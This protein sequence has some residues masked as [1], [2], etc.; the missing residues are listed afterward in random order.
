MRRSAAR[1]RMAAQTSEPEDR[2][3]HHGPTAPY[4]LLTE[5]Q[6]EEVFA[7][8]L[9]LLAETGVVFEPGTEADAMFR[10]AGCSISQDGIV[11]IPA[12]ITRRALDAT[13]R[14]AKLWNRDG[15]KA[16]EIDCN[17]TWFFPGMTCIKIFDIETG[18][19]RAS[20]RNDLA[21]ITRLA[22]GLANIDGVCVACKNVSRTDEFGEI[23]EFTC[24][25]E[26]T[27]KP[28]EYLC[29]NA[30]SLAAVIEMAATI[31]GGHEKLR[32]KPYF[33]Q[34]VTPL[35]LNYAATHIEQIIMAARAG[36]PVSTGTLPIGGASSPVT[37]AGCMAHSLATDF[38]GMMLAQFA[39]PGAFCIG[40]SD[41]CFMEPATGAIG[42]FALA[43][44]ADMAMC[45]IRRKLGLPSLTGIGGH[46]VARRFNQDA[47]WEISSNMTQAFY[48]RPATCDYLGSLDQGMTYSPHALLLCNE[49]AGLL[50]NLW[51]G[52]PVNEE[53]LALGLAKE[54][55][56]RGNYLA[57]RHTAVNCRAQ[58]W[59]SRYFGANIPLSNSAKLDQD[60][61]DRI[62]ADLREHLEN[63]V[64]AGLAPHIQVELKMIQQRYE[65]AGCGQG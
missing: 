55:G 12:E 23:D 11:R 62:D 8:A 20:T 63:H 52:I 32:Q 19:A 46:S 36:V 27:T 56:P 61:F 35:P 42:S 24:M 16:I 33:L 41:V 15:T 29:E 31:R 22:D 65:R 44:L 13:A 21:M 34:I 37:I 40:S 1:L 2:G 30:R 18:E 45:Q 43:S 54:V 59:N 7:A 39:S 25:I 47:V 4:S 50:R 49:L 6:L 57:H 17:H 48:S 53:Q 28:L 58:V 26:N 9:T 10:N 60:L 38:A 51:R 3:L 14:S 64:P 5:Q